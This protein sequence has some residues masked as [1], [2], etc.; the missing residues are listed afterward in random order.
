ML[1]ECIPPPVIF[2]HGRNQ[3][4]AKDLFTSL[5]HPLSE[6]TKAKISFF[7]NARSKKNVKELSGDCWLFISSDLGIECNTIAFQ[8]EFQ[9]LIRF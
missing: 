1:V 5:K 2:N 8:Q 4:E 9:D 7:L 3:T 6:F